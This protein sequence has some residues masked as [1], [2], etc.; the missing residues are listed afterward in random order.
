MTHVFQVSASVVSNPNFSPTV[1]PWTWSMTPAERPCPGSGRVALW[2]R[3]AHL[4][5]SGWAPWKEGW[6][7]TSCCLREIPSPCP[8]LP[9]QSWASGWDA[10]PHTR[11]KTCCPSQHQTESVPARGAW[12]RSPETSHPSSRPSW[13][14]PKHQKRSVAPCP[15]KPKEAERKQTKQE[16]GMLGRDRWVNQ[17][18]RDFT[19]QNMLE[20]IRPRCT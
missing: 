13:S 19:Q 15:R 18:V 4:E 11:S 8:S 2:F 14:S 12:T 16:D 1:R 17:W 6:G 20:R 10:G 9:L 5:S 7:S 3:P